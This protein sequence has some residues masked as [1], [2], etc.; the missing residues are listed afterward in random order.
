MLNGRDAT[1]LERT[2]AALAEGTGAKVPACPFDATDPAAVAEG[3]AAAEEP[4]V[5]STSS[6]TTP[7]CS[8]ADP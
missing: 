4:P 1:A 3:V 5:R 2:R 8:A 6:S 7:G